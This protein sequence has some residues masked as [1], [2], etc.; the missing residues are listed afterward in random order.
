MRFLGP[1][2]FDRLNE[3]LAFVF[4]FGGMFL[5]LSLVSYHPD[6]PSW[7]AV[8]SAA[9]ARNLTGPAGAHISDL[10]LQTFGFA[11]FAIPFLLWLLAWKWI[12]SQPIADAGVKII[13]SLLLLFSVCG[14]LALGPYWR[15]WPISF[16][17]GGCWERCWRSI[18][19]PF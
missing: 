18:R 17:P 14:G 12:R 5:I 13:G 7:N 19:S 4:L 8:S 15:S 6:D 1:T 3:A 16:G 2:R 9:R 11:A 10:L